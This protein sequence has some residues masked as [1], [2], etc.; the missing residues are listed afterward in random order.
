MELKD[1]LEFSLTIGKYKIAVADLLAVIMV[2]VIAK[3]FIFLFNKVLLERYFKRRKIDVGR[4][5]A[6]R[7]FITYI[8]YVL[9]VFAILEIV[10]IASVIWASAA[11]L[12]VGIGLGLQDAFKDLVSGII[13][14]VEGSVEIND[15]V[16]IDGMAAIVRR[17][18]LRTSVVETRNRVSILIPNSKLVMDSVTNMSHNKLP[19][20]FSVKVGVAYGSDV[21]LVRDLL[22]QVSTSNPHVLKTPAPSVQ[23]RDFGDSSLDF[24]LFFHSMEFFGIDIVK[25]DIRFIIN[26][27][28]RENNISIPFP[29]RDLWLKNPEA[30]SR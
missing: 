17:I 24:H 6:L 13:I 18:G 20:R 11:A 26:K 21:E 28:F 9:A 14:L 5:Y 2:I 7:Q 10:G 16:E 25:S 19:T 23:F 4:Q 3:L 8:I 30:L 27:L 22:L 29:Q 12:L 15:V 1:I